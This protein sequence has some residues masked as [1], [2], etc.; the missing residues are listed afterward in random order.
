VGPLRQAPSRT[1]R[2]LVHFLA[3][4]LFHCCVGPACRRSPPNRIAAHGGRALGSVPIGKSALVEID[5]GR[6]TF[7]AHKGE[8]I[9]SKRTLA[10]F[11]R[12]TLSCAP[13][14]VLIGDR[15][16][17]GIFSTPSSCTPELAVVFR[18]V[19]GC[20]VSDLPGS[21]WELGHR[22]FLAVAALPPP[23]AAHRGQLPGAIS[24]SGKPIPR[25]VSSS[26]LIITGPIPIVGASGG[27]IS[28]HRRA[29]PC[30]LYAPP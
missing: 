17:R 8:L 3:H 18:Q 29:P 27:E 6:G 22:G 30:G 20:V 10:F 23:P 24:V 12:P 11:P 19:L 1:A 21:I 28:C 2:A 25:F 26:A 14:G 13:N 9:P 5:R 16:R 7:H 15:R 4:A